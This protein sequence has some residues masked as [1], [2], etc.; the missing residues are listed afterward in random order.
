MDTIFQINLN[1]QSNIRIAE[2]YLQYDKEVD[3]ATADH[4][5]EEDGLQSS[6]SIG[7]TYKAK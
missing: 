3:T 7:L 1:F 6:S 4:S 5:E 2:T